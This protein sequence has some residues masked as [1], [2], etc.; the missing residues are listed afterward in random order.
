LKFACQLFPTHGTVVTSL[1][2]TEDD[3]TGAKASGFR[4]TLTQFKFL[5]LSEILQPAELVSKFLQTR[6]IS[7]AAACIDS[8]RTT[9]QL[10]IENLRSDVVFDTLFAE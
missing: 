2:E 6:N 10:H 7:V 3:D 5:F 9:L 4:T 1:T 8:S